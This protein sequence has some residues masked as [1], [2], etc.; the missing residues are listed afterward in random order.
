M[1]TLLISFATL[2]AMTISAS[3]LGQDAKPTEKVEQ[4]APANPEDAY[5]AEMMKMAMPGEFHKKLTPLVG[6]FKLSSKFRMAPG[7]P[8]T[9]TKST[10][11]AEW[12]LGD[13]FLAQKVV[14]D[15]I[16]GMPFP[17]EGF[18]IMGYDNMKKKYTSVW[19]DNLGTMTMVFEGTGSADGKNL[20]LLSEFIDPMT[21]A[22]SHMKLVYRVAGTER[23]ILQMYSP[24]PDG[25]EFMTM[26]IVHERVK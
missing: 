23:Y 16:M 24:G 21:G 17:Y 7:Q 10:S 1:K 19:M 8:W 3:V 14:G 5:M 12:I 11:E 6:S 26:E 18:G 2:A 22:K 9:E 13:R 15:P 20:T 25:K 4:K